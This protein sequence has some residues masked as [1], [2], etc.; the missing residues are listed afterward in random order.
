M[1]RPATLLNSLFD[2]ID[3]A[4]RY[5]GILCSLIIIWDKL[6]RKWKI[7]FDE[8]QDKIRFDENQ[9]NIINETFS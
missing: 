2:A 8:N 7:R 5:R 9:D 3:K 4:Y 1:G 6:T